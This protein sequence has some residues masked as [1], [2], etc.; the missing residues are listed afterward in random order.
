MAKVKYR[1]N[2]HT[3]SYDKIV[4]NF[5]TKLKR[6]LALFS[7][8]LVSSVLIAVGILQFYESPRMSSLRKENERLLTQYE[9]LY[10]DLSTVEKVLDEIEQRDNNLYRVVFESDPIPST[11]RRAGFGGVNKYSQLESFDNSELVIKTAEKLDILSKQAYIQSKSYDEVLTMAMNKEKLVSSMPAIM[12]ISNKSL[13]STASGWGYR[14]HPI[15]KI[16]Q[17]HYGM[18]FT[19]AVGTKVYTTGDGIVKDVQTIGGGYGRWILIDHGFG[20]QTMYAHLSG[21]SVKI[22]EQVKRGQVIGYVGNSGT[23]TGPHLHYEVHK[24]GEP[25]NPQYYYFKDLNAQ[26]YEK[27]VSISS[28]IGQTFD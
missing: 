27:M 5:K 24:N 7:T 21:F 15:Y 23:S 10:K 11:I 12:P 16:R 14:F 26:E 18:D 19:A 1:F 20:Y 25:V 17:F 9:L 22:G 8:T 3:L 28:T 2:A 6:F 13:K 4:I